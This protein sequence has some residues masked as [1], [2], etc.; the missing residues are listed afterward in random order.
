[1][2]KLR[3]TQ[4]GFTARGAEILQSKSTRKTV[5]VAPVA[6]GKSICIANTVARLDGPCIILQPNK[7]LLEQNYEKFTSYGYEASVFS[8][9]M[10]SK[11]LGHVTYAT[12]KSI[13]THV[14]AVKAMKYKYLI[15]DECHIATGTNGE[16]ATFIK[17]LRLKNVLGVTATPVLLHNSFEGAQLK[18]MDRSKKNLFSA[19]DYVVQVQ[20]LVDAGYWADLVYDVKVNSVPHLE[21]NGSGTE[22]SDE[23]MMN[24]YVESE[25]EVLCVRAIKQLRREGR[26]SIL[27]FVPSVQAAHDLAKRGT[28]CAVVHGKTPKAERKRI[29]TAFKNLELN[30]V[31][32]VNVL[33]TGFDHPQLDAIV[34]GRPT[35]SIA[36]YYQ[37]LGR[38]TRIHPLKENT[39]I[40]DLSGNVSNFGPIEEL[41]YEYIMGYG[42]GMFAN[43]ECL[44]HNPIKARHKRPTKQSLKL[45]H[46]RELV[47]KAKPHHKKKL[48]FGKHDG[49]TLDQ[50]P[51]PYLSYMLDTFSFDQP[52]MVALKESI[53]IVI[54]TQKT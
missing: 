44:T 30:T 24:A 52:K 13:K 47:A 5:M 14:E 49:L 31:I 9:S 38:G 27:V 35:A 50:C 46:S 8:H 39:K 32:N 19:I 16:I 1:M 28:D 6:Y 53:E 33:T 17:A 51:R 23:S 40:I 41:N 54:Q 7:E 4:E 45:A 34:M 12:I 15:I 25:T 2:L 26:K 10:N 43:D 21:Y 48:W 20:E 11:E 22:Y 18:T 42:W 36:L 29:L 37:M 3:G